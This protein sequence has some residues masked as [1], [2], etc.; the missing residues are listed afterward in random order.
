MRFQLQRKTLT[1]L[2]LGCLLAWSAGCAST[3]PVAP[4]AKP[5]VTVHAMVD[6]PKLLE[7][8]PSRSKLRQMEQA[9]AEA[10]A[11]TADNTA[12]METGRQEFEA[13]MKVR[14]NEDKAAIEKKQTQLGDELNEQRRLYIETLE[15]E[16]RPLLFNIDLKLTTVQ[17]SATE[18]QKLQQ[19]KD[20]LEGERRQKLTK[21][22]EELAARFQSE[23]DAFAADLSKKS[24]AY[25]DQWMADRMK[26]IQQ[27]AAPSPAMEKQRQEIVELSGRMIQDVR[28]AVTKVAIQ[29]KIDMV[30][31]RAAVRQPLKDITDQVARELANT[32]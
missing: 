29:E 25:A 13:A 16:Y 23:M 30:W 15:K 28:T 3:P 27:A 6:A 32:K 9:L 17:A 26:K 4:P 19:E 5:P 20:R 8:H 24:E 18:K 31:L 11:K 22:E 1:T 14:E 2:S 7:A 21:K 12:A 10:D